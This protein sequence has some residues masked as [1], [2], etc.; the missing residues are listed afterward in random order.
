M[1]IT[2]MIELP[3]NIP[4]WG[5]CTPIVHASL[6]SHVG[7]IKG[8]ITF[9]ARVDVKTS[10]KVR[11]VALIGLGIPVEERNQEK[12]EEIRRCLCLAGRKTCN[13]HKPS[14]RTCGHTKTVLRDTEYSSKSLYNC[15]RAINVLLSVDGGG[16]K[17]QVTLGALICLDRKA[18]SGVIDYEK[19]GIPKYASTNIFESI[20]ICA[21]TSTGALIA[22]GICTGESPLRMAQIYLKYKANLL[23]KRPLPNLIVEP[24][25]E[26]L[27]KEF[28]EF[29][30]LNDLPAEKT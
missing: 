9:G 28:G 3:K 5:F 22:F 8:L 4:P 23:G 15:K 2:D 14:R 16:A 12:C 18:K 25:H 11:A 27:E 6:R 21:G 19:S 26:V 24:L 17:G 20:K 10:M 30:R 1:E 13:G 7:M 29:K